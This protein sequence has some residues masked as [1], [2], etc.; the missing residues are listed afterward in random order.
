MEISRDLI[1]RLEVLAALRLEAPERERLRADLGRILEYVRQLEQLQLDEVEPTVHVVRAQQPLRRDEVRAS[2]P[3]E[4]IQR[5][6]PDAHDGFYR[7]PRFVT[8]RE[9]A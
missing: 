2:M 9:E 1:A 4:E 5:D 7:V 6:A 3:R 8:S